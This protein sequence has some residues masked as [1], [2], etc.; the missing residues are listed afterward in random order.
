MFGTKTSDELHLFRQAWGG[1]CEE[2]RREGGLCESSVGCG[3]LVVV[4]GS[5]SEV[6]VWL[7]LW[8]RCDCECECVL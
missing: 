4:G 8:R 2:R 1:G 3:R 5:A 7:W 6:G